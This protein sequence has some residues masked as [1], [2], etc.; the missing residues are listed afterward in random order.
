MIEPPV[1][2][3]KGLLIVAKWFNSFHIYGFT[4]CSGYLYSFIKNEKNGYQVYKE[5]VST[6]FKRLI[7]PYIF[8]AVIWTVPISIFVDGL[9]TSD[10]IERYVFVTNPSQLWFLWMLFDVFVIV[11]PLN[12]YLQKDACAVFVSV[13]SFLVGVAGS[14]LLPNIF[15]IWT[16]FSYWPFFVIGMKLREKPD[17]TLRK[18]SLWGYILIDIMLFVVQLYLSNQSGVVMRMLSIGVGFPLHLVGALMSFFLFQ[19]IA[20]FFADWKE[21]RVFRPLSRCSMTVYLFHQ[22]IIYYMIILFN[23]KVNPYINR[24]FPTSETI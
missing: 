14:A 22:Q 11:W 19:R 23:G 16:A 2:S 7:I 15:R 20:Q 17:W 9:K 18:I 10:I 1:Y 21:S 4:L 12:R 6:K 24:T 5:F 8:A 13:V 3:S